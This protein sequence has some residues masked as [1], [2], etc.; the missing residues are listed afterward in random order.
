MHSLGSLHRPQTLLRFHTVQPLHSSFLLWPQC[1]KS[2]CLSSLPPPQH[3]SHPSVFPSAAVKSC[4]AEPEPTAH[5][6]QVIHIGPSECT[7]GPPA[8]CIL[9]FQVGSNPL[10]AEFKHLCAA[11]GSSLG[12]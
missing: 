11:L 9:G 4:L 3:L 6:G 7:T 8:A 12:L 10:Q 2:L 1:L 5:C